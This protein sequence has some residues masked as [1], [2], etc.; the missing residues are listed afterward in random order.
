MKTHKIRVDHEPRET[1]DLNLGIGMMQVIEGV[2]VRGASAASDP[3]QKA[4]L[5]SVARQFAA[6]RAGP[7]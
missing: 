3:K 6:A 7:V 2:L 4:L 1:R 5:L